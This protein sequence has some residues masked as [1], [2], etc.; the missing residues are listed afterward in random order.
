[1]K[2]RTTQAALVALVTI[3]L[4]LSSDA[5]QRG[6]GSRT[7]A[8]DIGKMEYDSKCASC[9]GL[10]GKGDGLAGRSFKTRPTDLTKLAA[11]N[12][13]ILPINSMYDMIIGDKKP[14][15]HGSRDMPVWGPTYNRE[16]AAHYFE[17][18]EDREAY[19]RGRILF[20]I[21]YINRLQ[22]K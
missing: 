12:G 22:A 10:R 20:L 3:A 16:A 2:K 17:T 18:P 19:L 21:E 13:G 9:H 8:V 15:V 1:M 14:A 7:R 4:P 5:Q 11:N 6:A